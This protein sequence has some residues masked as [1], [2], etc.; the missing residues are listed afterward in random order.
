MKKESPSTRGVL[1]F[2]PFLLIPELHLFSPSS[3]SSQSSYYTVAYEPFFLLFM[4]YFYS[5]SRPLFC[6]LVFIIFIPFPLSLSKKGPKHFFVPISCPL[7]QVIERLLL[8]TELH[9][10][11]KGKLNPR[12]LFL[13]TE[14]TITPSLNQ[15]RPPTVQCLCHCHLPECHPEFRISQIHP[16]ELLM[17]L[18]QSN[19]FEL[20]LPPN[21]K[22]QP[23]TCMKTGAAVYKWEPRAQRIMISNPQPAQVPSLDCV[24]PLP[25]GQNQR[26]H[27]HIAL[28]GTKGPSLWVWCTSQAPK[29]NSIN[30]D[31]HLGF[32]LCL[33][34][35]WTTT[36]LQILQTSLSQIP[37]SVHPSS[38]SLHSH[39][40]TIEHSPLPHLIFLRKRKKCSTWFC[41]FLFL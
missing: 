3:I 1:N 34:K 39:S 41:F 25:P 7:I 17:K 11:K 13:F 33:N 28:L 29:P 2:F 10:C 9:Y 24:E 23:N 19:Q 40:P 12:S 31:N 26:Q 5:F 6:K 37:I 8:V 15:M 38:N 14:K 16:Q 21:S 36:L 32:S 4:M 30:D 27:V 18:V 22:P 35:T 20:T